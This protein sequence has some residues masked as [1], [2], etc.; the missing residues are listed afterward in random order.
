[1]KTESKRRRAI[2][3]ASRSAAGFSRRVKSPRRLPRVDAR[4]AQQVR[5]AT[6]ATAL[7]HDH[8][9]RARPPP[10]LPAAGAPTPRRSHIR[11]VSPRQKLSGAKVDERGLASNGGVSA[12]GHQVDRV[13]AAGARRGRAPRR[14]GR[15]AARG[16]RKAARYGSRSSA[17]TTSRRASR[18]VATTSA[19]ETRLTQALEQHL[20]VAT[21]QGRLDRAAPRGAAPR[22]RSQMAPQN[23]PRAPD[24]ASNG[25]PNSA[26]TTRRRA[27]GGPDL[28]A[29]RGLPRRARARQARSPRSCRHGARTSAAAGRQTRLQPAGVAG[30]QRGAE[31]AAGG[32]EQETERVD[33]D[34]GQHDERHG[35]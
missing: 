35:R 4:R 25:A 10:L 17:P 14:A 9:R 15:V 20:R 24:A 28:P 3:S 21:A 29:P 6:G 13:I 12:A 23:R 34:P 8:L 32:L 2:S 22:I 5:A 33:D 11:C 1:M 18:S 27:R 30:E 26:T 31:A 16:A 19:R 7:D